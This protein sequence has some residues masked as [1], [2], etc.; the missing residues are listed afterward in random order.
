MAEK[1]ERHGKGKEQ[2]KSDEQLA[3]LAN[4]R[5]ESIKETLEEAE[6]R[7][8]ESLSQ[9]EALEDATDLAED[10][11]ETKKNALSEKPA[12][13]RRSAPSK[14][15]L[16]KSFDTEIKRVQAEMSPGSRLVSKIMHL[17]PVDKASDAVSSTLARPNALLSG[18][19]AAFISI[20]ILYFIARYYGYRL[21][22][23][24][25]IAAFSVG[26]IL[27]ILYDYLSNY[28]RKR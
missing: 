4:E 28:F 21:S 18:S 3:E 15:Q 5:K 17:G 19:V 12:E 11:D 2:S 13:I 25:T 10:A 16:K 8:H 7:H 24:E 22:G 9:K 1:L 26:W 6:R 14:K 20:T 23:F 27:G